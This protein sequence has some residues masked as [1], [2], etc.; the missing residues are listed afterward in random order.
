MGV[1]N[2]RGGLTAVSMPARTR[3]ALWSALKARHCYGTT[4][5]R[6]IV[7]LSANGA[8]MG[9]EIAVEQLP[10][11]EAMV[12]G[13]APLECIDFFRDDTLVASRDLMEETARGADLLSNTIRVGWCGTTSPGNWQ[14]ARMHWDGSLRIAGARLS[15]VEPWAFDTPDEGIR[16]HDAHRVHWRSITAGDWDGVLVTLEDCASAEATF[17]SGPMT[18]RTRLSELDARPRTF[19]AA[20]PARRVELRRLPK[21][22]PAPGW[23]GT[24]S[25]PSRDMPPLKHGH[26]AYWLRVRQAD[27]A[28]AWSSPIFVTLT[29]RA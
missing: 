28:Y 10:V 20:N 19:E 9:D 4:G 14:R 11:F 6:I 18:L 26:H 13:T 22:M 5:P 21:A 1:R 16:E 15:N 2:V 7:R 12:E 29:G 17:V 23:S 8:Q 27:G 3:S 24:F 25:D